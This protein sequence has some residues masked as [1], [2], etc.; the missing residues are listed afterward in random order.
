MQ[1]ATPAEF[2]DPRIHKP[3]KCWRDRDA[4]QSARSDYDGGD[5]YD[6]YGDYYDGGDQA[7]GGDDDRRGGCSIERKDFVAQSTGLLTF[8]I[9]LCPCSYFENEIFFVRKTRNEKL[10]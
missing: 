2:R 6:Y 9:K 10:T 7:G 4:S 8:I 1:I 3:C 5:H